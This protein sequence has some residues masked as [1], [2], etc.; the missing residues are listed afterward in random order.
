MALSQTPA[1]RPAAGDGVGAIGVYGLG[2]F[3][4]AL[5][6]AAFTLV[7]SNIA[8]V[9]NTAAPE[10][11]SGDTL[12]R[13]LNTYGIILPVL[14]AGAGIYLALLG[15]RIFQR[16]VRAANWARQI[17]LWLTIAALVM[18]V[19]GFSAGSAGPAGTPGSGV[20]NALPWLAAAALVGAAYG[21]LGRSLNL[22][23]GVETLTEASARSAWNLLLPTIAIMII[24]AL[25]PL[26]KTFVASLT[27]DRFADNRP[28][29][30]VGFDNY[31]QLL[32]FRIDR[33]EC[34][35]DESG[36]CQTNADGTP[37]F[38]RPRDVLDQGYTD[39]RFR[40]ATG[41]TL[42]D[43]RWIFSARGATGIDFVNSFSNTLVFTVVSVTLELI[44]G[45]FIAM[46]INSKF[47]GRGL[48]RAAMLIP[49]AIPTVVSARL[50]EVMLRPDSSGVI[51]RFLMLTGIVNQPQAWLAASHLQI[52]AL[53][54]V[55]VWKT[56]PFMALILLAGL[57]VISGDL[58][59]AAD[60]DGASKVRQFFSIT[61]PLLRP[62]IA[63]A[64]VFRTLDAVRVF[65]V[66]QVLLEN[67]RLSLATF[68]Y[69][70][71]ILDQELG[72]ASAIGVV[73]FV[74]ILVFTVIY[75]RI[76]GVSA[77]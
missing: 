54:F 50:W 12:L 70:T 77:E 6:A 59:E 7:V 29:E 45:L 47:K 60:V 24:V 1:R 48:M 76:L 5:A 17:L 68:N 41:I 64:L 62:A 39:F 53:I 58:Y 22:F 35:R 37:V 38:P 11:R 23:R 72:L 42:G 40:E 18:A 55:D 4:L 61:L 28:A 75:V 46:V 49:W 69:R 44:L 8:G 56:T 57:Q 63:V 9:I 67:T 65:D 71:L 36:A 73:I 21:W 74:I 2:L 13:F 30:Y 43:T 66:F 25:R 19:Q 51:N 31:S 10:E 15:V 26:E 33:L 27:N 32:S 52:P 3:F 34:S 16:D 14:I 20:Q